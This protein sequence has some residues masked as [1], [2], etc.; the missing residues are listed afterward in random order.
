[1]PESL[2]ER[3]AVQ[4][5]KRIR[6]PNDGNRRLDNRHGGTMAQDGDH[7]IL[8]LALSPLFKILIQ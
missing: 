1:M 6:L 3:L 4:K 7:I 8:G 2:I 5:K